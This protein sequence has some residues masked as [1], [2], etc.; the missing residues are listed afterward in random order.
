MKKIIKMS[1][2]L[3]LIIYALVIGLM[4][5]LAMIKMSRGD[6]LTDFTKTGMVFVEKGLNG[7]VLVDLTPLLRV[8]GYSAQNPETQEFSFEALVIP[9]ENYN[10][11]ME[12]GL[13][14]TEGVVR[15]LK[16]RG[17]KGEITL[18]AF[19]IVSRVNNEK[20][21]EVLVTEGFN[22]LTNSLVIIAKENITQ[23][24]LCQIVE[25]LTPGCLIEQI[26]GKNAFEITMSLKCKVNPLELVT[27]LSG[28]DEIKFVAPLFIQ[29]GPDGEALEENP[30]PKPL[31][32]ELPKF[33]I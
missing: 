16:K 24:T 11:Y 25:S 31:K 33:N 6:S 15:E 14:A 22:L 30:E 18:P 27:A 26:V 3:V 20:G 21:E 4:L 17:E 10:E 28:R 19:K 29:C 13:N 7:Q 32:K 23:E 1:F 2:I 12:K 5:G 8:S 9:P